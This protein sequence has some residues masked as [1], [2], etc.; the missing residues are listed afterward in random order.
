MTRITRGAWKSTFLFCIV[1]SITS[2]LMAQQHGQYQ[3]GQ[4]G[5]N[6]GIMPDPGF[7]YGDYNLNFN[8]HQLNLENGTPV[9]ATGTYNIW[10]VENFF[11]Y[12][13]KFKILGAKFAPFVAFPTIGDG[14]VV[15]PFLGNGKTL[16][17]GGF[18]LADTWFQLA[19]LAWHA[20]RAD[21]W[22]G[23][24]FVAPTG[25][26]TP[27]ATT[28]VGSGY[29]GNDFTSG[30][31]FYITKDQGTTANFMGNWEI[32]GSKTTRTGDISTMFG[33]LPINVQLTPGAAWSDEWGLGQA[34]PLNKPFLKTK[35][36]TKVAQIG[37]IGYDQ[38]QLSRNRSNNTVV[39]AFERLVPFYY[40]HA[41]GGQ[42]NYIDLKNNWNVFFKYEKE[43]QALATSKGT[44]IVFGVVYTLRIPKPAPGAPVTP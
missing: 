20:P 14:S 16:G 33:T 28:N 37:I 8:A 5:L 19:N 9:K 30:A 27:G 15:L 22:A 34:I 11:F 29:W 41:A 31:T 7:S 44:T 36:I 23:Y 38:A 32:H 39:D 1:L 35:N 13:P 43:Y 40:M 24:A 4:Y 12:V 42:V 25:R 21:F 17:S 26:Y 3:P 2:S 18:A 6:A 10:A